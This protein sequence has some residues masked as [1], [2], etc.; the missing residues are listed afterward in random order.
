MI[1]VNEG[2]PQ[3]LES[4]YPPLYQGWGQHYLK[5]GDYDHDGSQDLAILQSVGHG[6]YPRCYSV[7]RYSSAIGT[8]LPRR[9][10]D[11]CGI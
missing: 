5:I 7:Y 9:S 8:F 2:V 4:I 11:L 3:V 6:G 10:F 1:Q